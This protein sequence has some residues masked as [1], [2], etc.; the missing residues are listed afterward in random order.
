MVIFFR[1][2]R[3]R[4]T[5]LSLKCAHTRS[6]HG[7]GGG[8]GEAVLKVYACVLRYTQAQY[9]PPGDGSGGGSSG[10]SAPSHLGRPRSVLPPGTPCLG[11][12]TFSSCPTKVNLKDLGE[13]G[14]TASRTPNTN[15]E[16]EVAFGGRLETGSDGAVGKSGAEPQGGGVCLCVCGRVLVKLFC[17][18]IDGRRKWGGS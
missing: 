3:G 2:L 7:G 1:H 10:C 6:A 13:A 4:L 16:T 5:L 11:P 12:R 9:G 18:N 17:W 8:A 14:S 15:G